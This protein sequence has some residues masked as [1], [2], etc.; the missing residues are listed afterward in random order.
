MLRQ[1]TDGYCMFPLGAPGLQIIADTDKTGRGDHQ[2]GF[3]GD[4]TL[5]ALFK[6]F[7]GIQMPAGNRPERGVLAAAFPQQYFPLF[8]YDNHPYAS[9]YRH[10]CLRQQSFSTVC[11]FS[12]ATG[13]PS[14]KVCVR[15]KIYHINFEKTC[16]QPGL[17]THSLKRFS[18]MGAMIPY[19]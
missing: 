6:G 19:R 4:L 8:I 7:T 2:P 14:G 13:N 17:L 11:H 15:S 12:A 18:V 3:F 16:F 5:S 9:H 10:A 1:Q